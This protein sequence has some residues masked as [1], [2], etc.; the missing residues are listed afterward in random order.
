MSSEGVSEVL[1]EVA[2]VTIRS[3]HTCDPS[4]QDQDVRTAITFKRDICPKKNKSAD[5]I[6]EIITGTH[7]YGLC[8]EFARKIQ[9]RNRLA[10]V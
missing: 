7:L 6:L 2:P 4:S 10:L 3:T 5:P 8:R 1:E 9:N